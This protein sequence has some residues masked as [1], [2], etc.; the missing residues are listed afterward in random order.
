MTVTYE[1]TNWTHEPLDHSYK[2]VETDDHG[3]YAELCSVCANDLIEDPPAYIWL[4]RTPVTNE[5]YAL[6]ACESCGT[7]WRE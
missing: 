6:H 1:P 2:Y 7:P 5:D 4:E 3:R